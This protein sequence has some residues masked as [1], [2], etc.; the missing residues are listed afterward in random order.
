MSILDKFNVVKIDIDITVPKAWMDE[1]VLT[2]KEWLTKFGIGVKEVIIRPS[3]KKGY[4][5][6]IHLTDYLSYNEL[7]FVKFLCGD[8]C[9]RIWFH[10]QRTGFPSRR[11]FDLLFSEK[12]RVLRKEDISNNAA[13]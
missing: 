9:N 6:W 10:R 2:R 8:D 4:H 7:E 1:W 13:T 11:F 5:V 3:S 12:L